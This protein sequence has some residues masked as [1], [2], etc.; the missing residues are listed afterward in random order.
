MLNVD[1]GDD[2][3]PS[4]GISIAKRIGRWEKSRRRFQKPEFSFHVCSIK[5]F[6]GS[7]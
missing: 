3:V 5:M 2:D 7:T 6:G 4:A 1:D